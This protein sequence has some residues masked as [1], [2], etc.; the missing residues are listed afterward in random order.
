MGRMRTLGKRKQAELAC[1]YGGSTG[2]LK[3]MG[4]LESG[5]LEDELSPSRCLEASTRILFILE[6]SRECKNQCS[7]R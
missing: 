3:A 5:M 4:A 2:A 1:G 6:G 7:K